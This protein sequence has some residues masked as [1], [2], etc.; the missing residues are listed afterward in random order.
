MK[1]LG[2][3]VV[4][5]T[6]GTKTLKDATNEAMRDW[7]TNVR[8]THYIIGSVVG[9]HP[10]P[11]IVR[12]FQ[13]VI[14]DETRQQYLNRYGRLPEAVIACV[15]GGSNA[16]GFFTAFV[17]DADVKIVGV[18]AGG[19]GLASGQHAAPLTAGQ[20]GVLHGAYSYLMQD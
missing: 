20:P 4:P 9:P 1:L 14:G 16:I 7:V 6:S 8:D 18:E 17:P 10:F 15:G 5:V 13:R 12:Q 11:Y 3:K 2:A 19:L